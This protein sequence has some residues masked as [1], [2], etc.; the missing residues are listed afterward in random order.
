MTRDETKLIIQAMITGYPNYKPNN[1]P[2][3]IDLWTALFA[4]VSYQQVSKALHSY[5]M[6]DTK[7]FPPTPGQLNAHIVEMQKPAARSEIDA[8]SLVS[9][10]IRNGAYN[11]DKEFAKLPP[12]IQRVLG[13]PSQ[14]RTWAM[15]EDYNESV[16]SSQFMRNYRTEAEREERRSRMPADVRR[17]IESLNP[18]PEAPMLMEKERMEQQAWQE[19]N[20]RLKEKLDALKGEL[21]K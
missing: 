17:L 6:S 11:A 21:S 20:D 13:S 19:I 7:G 9:K 16:I 3:T 4:D 2:A 18:A 10:A 1:L 12:T 8:W 15:D 14:L 5:M